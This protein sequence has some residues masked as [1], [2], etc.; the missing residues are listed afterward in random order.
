MSRKF[1]RSAAARGYGADWTK[2]RAA[3]LLTH[4]HCV[5][6]LL[7]DRPMGSGMIATTV[8]HITPITGWKDPGRLAW[9]N[10]QPLCKRC[11]FKDKADVQRR[12]TRRETREAWYRYLVEVQKCPESRL[13]L[14][15]P[16]VREGME[17]V[18]RGERPGNEV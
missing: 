4:P 7:S 15:P 12:V 13:Q 3:F 9:G 6:C 17:A 2:L 5:L 10:L 1:K 16:H 14:L 11:H 8:D 18:R